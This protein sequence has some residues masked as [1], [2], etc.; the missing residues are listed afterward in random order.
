M[1][2]GDHSA[3]VSG[4]YLV[5][6]LS[7]ESVSEI[8][9]D[10]CKLWHFK[11]WQQKQNHAAM[12]NLPFPNNLPNRIEWVLHSFHNCFEERSNV[13]LMLKQSCT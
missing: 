2:R 1:Q 11:Q 5:S 10:S 12:S 13:P 6:F 7:I 9:Q 4:M 3:T 8:C